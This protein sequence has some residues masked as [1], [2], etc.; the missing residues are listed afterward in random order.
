MRSRGH[1]RSSDPSNASDSPVPA[2]MPALLTWGRGHLARL[3]RAD[4][5]LALIG[6]DTAGGAGA[7]KWEAQQKYG[8]PP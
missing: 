3:E 2:G 7:I 8:E 5:M 1:R 4:G 6:V